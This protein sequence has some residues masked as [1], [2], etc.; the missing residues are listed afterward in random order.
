MVAAKEFMMN[1]LLTVYADFVQ[2][3][4]KFNLTQI[5]VIIACLLLDRFSLVIGVDI[6]EDDQ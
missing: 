1:D 3:I 5:V 4:H 2:V 6:Y